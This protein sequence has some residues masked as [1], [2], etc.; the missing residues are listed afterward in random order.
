[1]KNRM[2]F[3]SGRALFV[4]LGLSHILSLTGTNFLLSCVLGTIIGI[5]LLILI[6]S[7]IIIKY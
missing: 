4:G 5:I 2:A 6:S 7:T 3:F 1:M